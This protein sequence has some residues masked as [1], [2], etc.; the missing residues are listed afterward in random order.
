MVTTWWEWILIPPIT[1]PSWLLL[2]LTSG[3]KDGMFL[4]SHCFDPWYYDP[5]L[6]FLCS[7]LSKKE[8]VLAKEEEKMEAAGDAFHRIKNESVNI[9][10][11]V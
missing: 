2:C 6:L 7:L 1:H 5:I 4:L 10:K 11:Q 9:E 3:A 8:V